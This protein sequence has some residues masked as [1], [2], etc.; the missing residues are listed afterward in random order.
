MPMV[1][2]LGGPPFTS[3]LWEPAA[4][5]LHDAHS[6]DT[7]V[8]ELFDPLPSTPTVAGLADHLAARLPD[9][10][11]PTILCAHGAALPVAWRLAAEERVDGL[12]L[13]NGPIQALDPVLALL[14]AMAR[15]PRVLAETV[16]RPGAFQAWLASSVGLRRAVVNPYVMDR[17][18]VV[19]L[20]DP[21]LRPQD[22]RLAVARYLADLNRSVPVP[23]R[24][25]VPTLLC[26]GDGDP[27]YSA[28]S[29][30][31][32]LSALDNGRHVRVPG[33]QHL[34]P[35]ERPWFIADEMAAWIAE[36][37]PEAR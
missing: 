22:T 17:D 18:T 20:S 14:A 30:D 24:L 11:G 34:H 31:Q 23:Q 21:L 19:A 35:V 29:A 13:S 32:A 8:I 33:G 28:A 25:K 12:V 10:A 27:L 15:A 1:L 3:Q 36:T 16:L 2:F 6:V 26:W 7:S 4:L 9:H 37:W 5:R